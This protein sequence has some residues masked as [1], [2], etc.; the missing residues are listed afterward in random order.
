MVTEVKENKRKSLIAKIGVVFLVL[1]LFFTFFSKS[2]N[3]MLLPK[4]DTVKASKGSLAKIMDKTGR[5]ELIDK[6]KVYSGGSWKVKDVFIKKNDPVK[7]DMVLALFDKEDILISLKQKELEIV[8]LENTINNY[9]GNDGTLKEQESVVN[10]KKVELSL[11]KLELE[12]LK[13]DL[14]NSGEIKADSYGIALEVNVDKGM[15]T[16]PNQPVFVIGNDNGKYE[17][18]WMMS[19]EEAENFNIGDKVDITFKVLKKG[20]NGTETEEVTLKKE[21][22]GKEYITDSKQYKYWVDVQLEEGLEIEGNEAQIYSVKYSKNYDT[23]IGALGNENYVEVRGVKILEEDKFYCAI[24]APITD[25]EEIVV[26]TTKMLLDR[27][28]VR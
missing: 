21:I 17:V 27:M 3:N 18:F 7:K 6:E 25:N 2:I 16:I 26:N 10:E 23:I 14:S 8:K 13:K 11:R 19:G 1:I 24:D 12:K 20:E 22:Q 5:I 15:V 9:N 4:V 28:Q